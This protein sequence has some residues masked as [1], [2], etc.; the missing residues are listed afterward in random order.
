MRTIAILV[1]CAAIAGSAVARGPVQ[2]DRTDLILEMVRGRATQQHDAWFDDGDF[3]R[4]IQSLRVLHELFPHDYGLETDLGWMLE[5]V[6]DYGGAIAVYVSYRKAFPKDPEAYYPEAELYFR[7]HLYAKVPPLIEPS[8]R[9]GQRPQAN[10]YRILAGSYERLG[11][12]KDSE[13]VWDTYLAFAKDDGQAKVNRA[14]VEKKRTGAWPPKPVA[15]IG[16]KPPSGR[17]SERLGPP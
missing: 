1:T 13:R 17:Q 9:L 2:P 15:A 16:A 12:F 11:L 5:N 10:S 4:A 7:E 6:E 3:P 14:R 8:M